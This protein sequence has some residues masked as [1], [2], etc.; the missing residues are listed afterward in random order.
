M[1][2]ASYSALKAKPTT[3]QAQLGYLQAFPKSG[4]KFLRIFMDAPTYG[5][6]Y[7]GH[8][9]IEALER[10]GKT[11]PTQVLNTCFS[12]EKKLS[13][14]S[15]AVAYLADAM[16]KLGIAHPQIFTAEAKHLAAVDQMALCRFLAD[17]EDIEHDTAYE[18]LLKRLRQTGAMGLSAKLQQAKVR[19]MKQ[20]ND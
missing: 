13:R 2:R 12:I 3:A 19:R 14:T 16:V 4:D 8:E 1:V 15:D 7:D 6:L 9:Y 18:Q 17:E 5:Q 20:S 10:L 11:Y